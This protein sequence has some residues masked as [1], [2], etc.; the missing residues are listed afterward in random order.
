MV[1][2]PRNSLGGFPQPLTMLT[3]RD[4]RGTFSLYTKLCSVLFWLIT[5]VYIIPLCDLYKE[6]FY[7]YKKKTAKM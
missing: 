6:V 1:V 7:S 3:S 5:S 4:R 2:L